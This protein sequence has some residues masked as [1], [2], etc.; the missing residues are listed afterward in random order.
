[1]ADALVLS[2]ITKVYDEGKPFEVHAI[3]DISFSVEKGELISITGTSGSGKSTLLHVLGLLDN[4]SSG[5][6][7]LNGKNVEKLSG[8]DAA[9]ERNQNIG[10]VFQSFNLLRRASV[11][12]NVELPLL[13]STKIK[14]SDRK[15]QIEH[16]L[17]QVGL[18]DRSRNKSNELSGGQ[19]Q[20][21]AIARALVT[22]PEFI[23]ADEPTG[24]LDTKRG[25]EII[26]I[27]VRLNKERGT[28][29]IIVTHDAEIAKMTNRRIALRDGK[30][31]EDIRQ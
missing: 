16:V 31:V 4:P 27:L 20:R 6:Y 24:N 2:H 10:F 21:V 13:Y 29:I 30:I 28:T 5:S 14:K 19:Q 17:E 23:L 12:R 15:K 8:R 1:M 11:Y 26:D 22:N 3:D 9:Y 7:M 18:A 25:K